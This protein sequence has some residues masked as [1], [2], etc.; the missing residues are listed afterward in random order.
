M[1]FFQRWALIKGYKTYRQL[2][3]GWDE[4]QHP[5]HPAGS[6]KGGEFAP[7][8]YKATEYKGP[9]P[10]PNARQ[11]SERDIVYPAGSLG[12]TN[13][14]ERA[15]GNEQDTSWYKV[16]DKIEPGAILY[17]SWGYDQTNVDFYEVVG[18]TPSGKSALIRPMA[19]SV[20]SAGAGSD[21][22]TPDPK[23]L[24]GKGHTMVKRIKSGERVRIASY[25]NAHLWD[26][27]PKHQ[28]AFGYGH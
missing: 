14:A 23:D 1:S 19:Q 18:L 28:T 27:K 16:R 8:P 13:I 11:P 5:R 21:N 22:V 12:R 15:G 2:R 24:K 6:D 9:K 25:A 26:G 20:V 7:K 3:E 10:W 4:S 17:T